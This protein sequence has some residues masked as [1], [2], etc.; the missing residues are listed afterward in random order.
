MALP[1]CMQREALPP[2][3]NT[4]HSFL[5]WEALSELCPKF[6]VQSKEENSTPEAKDQLITP[7]FLSTCLLCSV[8]RAK[9]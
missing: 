6:I 1:S 4:Q 3:D 5:L 2:L 9:M 8:Q 7:D